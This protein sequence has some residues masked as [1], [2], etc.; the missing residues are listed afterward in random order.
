MCRADAA[1]S[2]H[3]APCSGNLNTRTDW[4]MRARLWR[5]ILGQSADGS[6]APS[7]NVAFSLFACEPQELERVDKLPRRKF[8]LLGRLADLFDEDADFFEDVDGARASRATSAFA[9]K[10]VMP[11]SAPVSVTHLPLATALVRGHLNRR[12]RH[13]QRGE[14]GR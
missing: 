2:L 11:H 6:W 12:V 1:L 9:Y 14:G 13:L 8:E 7:A 5:L 3:R 10:A 4:L